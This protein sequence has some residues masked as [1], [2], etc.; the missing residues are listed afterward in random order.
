MPETT[1]DD[2]V[3][4]LLLAEH[5]DDRTRQRLRDLGDVA[6]EGLRACARGPDRGEAAV[7]KA[8]ALVA[9]GDWPADEAVDTLAG[10]LDDRRLEN[11]MRAAAALGDVAT[12]R[13]VSVLA[14]R[15]EHC[16]DGVELAAI[17]R[18]LARIDRDD[19]HEALGRLRT[20]VATDDVRRQVDLLLDERSAD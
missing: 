9:L 19:A 18:S 8:R 12:D 17:A 4:R 7:L 6:L 3:R 5:F 13:A 14:D 2:R 10:A 16:D 20:S 15:A 1:L 11:R